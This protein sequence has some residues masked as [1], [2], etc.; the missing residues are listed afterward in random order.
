MK[1]LKIDFLKNGLLNEGGLN[2]LDVT[3]KVFEDN[4]KKKNEKDNLFVFE[5]DAS[6]SMDCAATE[7]S[8][9]IVGY[10]SPMIGGINHRM[11]NEPFNTSNITTRLDYAKK[12]VK[13]F[14]K[15]LSPKDKI[16]IITF[17]SNAKIVQPITL[18]ENESIKEEIYRHID[19]INTS[20]CTNMGE[21]LQYARELINEKS[22]KNYNCKIIVLSDGDVNM[23]MDQQDLVELSQSFLEKG[24]TLSSLGIGTDY[25]SKL[26]EDIS[27]N[28]FYHIKDLSMLDEIL[29]EELSMNNRIL[30]NNAK[31]KVKYN[32]LIEV[33]SNLNDLTEKVIENEKVINL[34]NIISNVE[35]HI[36]FEINNEL[37]KEKIDFEVNLVLDENNIVTC[38]KNLNIVSKKELL[39][40]EEDKEVAKRVVDLLKRKTIQKTSLDYMS[41]GDMTN[42]QSS[43]ND[44]TL[45]VGFI[46][47][48]IGMSAGTEQLFNCS[49]EETR[50]ITSSYGESDA[51]AMKNIYCSNSNKSRLD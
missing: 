5:I 42:V 26:M 4:A 15:L 47:N 22:L 39:E 12:S 29:K 33:G 31:L 36:V 17:G 3:I 38:K 49:I 41:N 40:I 21:G 7:D 10:M 34:G 20:G 11:Y 44:Y 50:G 14:I 6:G 9:R 24:I 27:T 35:K 13:N 37:E 16:C 45:K 32:G 23:G 25:N 48:A 1:E 28:L 18:L 2:Y 46:S 30:Y 8:N 51:N 19:N 43:L